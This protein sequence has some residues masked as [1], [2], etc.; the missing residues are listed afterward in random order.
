AVEFTTALP[1]YS[2]IRYRDVLEAICGLI[3]HAHDQAIESLSL[4]EQI[5]EMMDAG[6]ITFG[7]KDRCHKLRLLCNSGAHRKSSLIES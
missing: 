2:L 4:F 5:N 1:S 6:R 3:A 7:F